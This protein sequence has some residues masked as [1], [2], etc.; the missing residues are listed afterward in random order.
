[1]W[2]QR[3]GACEAL[4]KQVFS[5][6]IPLP[7]EIPILYVS[8]LGKIAHDVTASTAVKRKVISGRRQ[9]TVARQLNGLFQRYQPSMHCL[10]PQGQLIWISDSS[11]IC[12]ISKLDRAKQRY[13]LLDFILKLG[14]F[15]RKTN[16]FFGLLV[17]I[18]WHWVALVTRC[19]S[20][21][22]T[23]LHSIVDTVH[24]SDRH[25]NSRVAKK[26]SSLL[27]G[28]NF[29]NRDGSGLNLLRVKNKTRK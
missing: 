24:S 1:M 26:V 29:V 19:Y 7:T 15:L 25:L 17:E 16:I 20:H 21:T 18:L 8:Y 14:P 28:T 12:M 10:S 27:L 23:R 4:V 2:P 13:K 3:L 5:C 22:S 11:C 6:T 9:L